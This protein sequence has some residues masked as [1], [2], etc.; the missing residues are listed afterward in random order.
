MKGES[1]LMLFTKYINT[2]FN[3]LPPFFLLKGCNELGSVAK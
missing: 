2:F 1:Y 3:H